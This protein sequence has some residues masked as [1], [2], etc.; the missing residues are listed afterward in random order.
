MKNLISVKFLLFLA[1]CKIFFKADLMPAG[2]AFR[3]V[4]DPSRKVKKNVD[5]LFNVCKVKRA[6]SSFAKTMLVARFSC[7]RLCLYR[8]HGTPFIFY[9]N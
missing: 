1:S 9:L 2:P 6:T 5:S 8:G 4:G 7:L 3:I